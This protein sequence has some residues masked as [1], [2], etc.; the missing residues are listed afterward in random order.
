M[1]EMIKYKKYLRILL[2]R[3]DIFL[4]AFIFSASLLM[5][6]NSVLSIDDT[7]ETFFSGEISPLK[8][9]HYGTWVIKLQTL[10]LYQLPQKLNINI[11]DWSLMFSGLIKSTVITFLMY[12]S[13]KFMKLYKISRITVFFTVFLLFYMY[14]SYQI[15]LG[16]SDFIINEGFFRFVI[17]SLLTY[18][19]LY[20]LYKFLAAGVKISKFGFLCIFLCASSSEISAVICLTVCFCSILYFI[21]NKYSREK[22]KCLM[23]IFS[24]MAA[25]A[26]MLLSSKGFGE[27]FS[28]KFNSGA[29]NVL[30]CINNLPEFLSFFY[31]K[32]ICD[33]GIF[34]V[35][36]I[37]FLCLQYKKISDIKFVFPLFILFSCL[38]FCFSLI[39]LGKTSYRNNFWID[40][41]DIYT[42]IAPVIV[43]AVLIS[44]CNTIEA[45]NKYIKKQICLVLIITA[46]VFSFSLAGKIRLI[47]WTMKCVK[48]YVYLLDKMTLFYSYKNEIPIFPIPSPQFSVFQNAEEMYYE[49]TAKNYY[50]QTVYKL[51]EKINISERIVMPYKKAAE[52][53]ELDGGSA[54][55]I[56]NR[57]IKFAKLENRN[58]VLSNN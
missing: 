3:A 53:F 20:Y 58:F 57:N 51:P 55:E 4:F 29:F 6:N 11:Q 10:L 40:H 48:Q 52:K 46:F 17:P 9:F 47:R 13:S 14:I 54:S 24:I 50:Y 19:A 37:L 2:S 44:F 33:F 12:C 32:L 31:D 22:I 45:S 43:L 21:I 38:L 25:G 35:L 7:F 5:L 30:D 56:K 28:S 41:P 18:T 26:F 27:H 1:M 15:E 16:L 34:Y 42:I 36:I 49:H 39:I 23:L 8:N